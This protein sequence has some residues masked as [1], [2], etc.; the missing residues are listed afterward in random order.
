MTVSN[1]HLIKYCNYFLA[2]M[3]SPLAIHLSIPQRFLAFLQEFDDDDA[4]IIG[5]QMLASLAIPDG[6]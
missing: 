3:S 4:R 6:K 5:T 1:F 2:A